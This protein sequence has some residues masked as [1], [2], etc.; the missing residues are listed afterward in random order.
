MENIFRN[1]SK[2][3]IK[4]Y[5]S[6][7]DL[8]Y[9]Q[10]YSRN[11]KSD[12]LHRCDYI[13]A[14]SYSKDM[15]KWFCSNL[16]FTNSNQSTLDI[17]SVDLF[18]CSD[19]DNAYIT[20][21]QLPSGVIIYDF[22]VHV[23]SSNGID[24]EFKPFQFVIFPNNNSKSIKSK[25]NIY[26][27]AFR[28]E[29]VCKFSI[30][31]FFLYVFFG[32]WLYDW[33]P[34]FSNNLELETLLNNFSVQHSQ[35]LDFVKSNDC[36]YDIFKQNLY[37]N[38]SIL[39][40]FLSFYITRFDYCYD[41]FLD[42]GVNCVDFHRLF[43]GKDL[44]FTPYIGG[45]VNIPTDY[46]DFIQYDKKWHMNT[47]WLYQNENR[48]GI[49]V[50]CY[51]K[52]I[53][54][55]I[56]NQCD[57]YS[58]YMNSDY[59]VRRLEFEFH[60]DFCCPCDKT[61]GY[62]GR[63]SLFSELQNYDLSKRALSYL[64]LSCKDNIF[65]KK[66][67]IVVDWENRSFN[68]QYKFIKKLY[69]MLKYIETNKVPVSFY[70]EKLWYNISILDNVKSIDLISSDKYKKFQLDNKKTIKDSEIYFHKLKEN[71]QN[72][73][74]KHTLNSPLWKDQLTDLLNLLN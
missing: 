8:D 65:Y 25:I 53:K 67:D 32:A 45:S 14:V 28:A 56:D 17:S 38:I 40:D 26:G 10:M 27:L 63:V 20:K 42:K 12:L 37:I 73:Y 31:W 15:F 4:W 49:S 3:N 74:D 7:L 54:L 21:T 36:V 5:N 48:K 43:R 59:K 61:S 72:Q 51:D 24:F 66:Y 1:Y 62:D 2:D 11:I 58:E 52:Q 50:R 69:N 68:W 23:F 22:S 41:F 13:S 55:I 34:D 29:K 47:G 9:L 6:K 60:S 35:L 46:T 16:D 71:L 57:F 30:L 44:K 39:Q 18:D 70:L 33:C 19:I 64:W